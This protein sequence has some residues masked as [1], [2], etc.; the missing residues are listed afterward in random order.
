MCG[1]CNVWVCVCGFCN[2]WVCGF[3]N[4]WVFVC[5][6]F[7]MCGCVC[8]C[9]CVG[10]L[11]IYAPVFTVFVL[12]RLSMLTLICYQCKDYCHRVK[13]KFQYIIIIIITTNTWWQL[14]VAMSP[15]HTFFH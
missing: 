3:C 4:V 6:G 8:V 11:V 1:F 7:V 13:T 2:V 5:V 15:C 10:V 12:F 9:V 14:C